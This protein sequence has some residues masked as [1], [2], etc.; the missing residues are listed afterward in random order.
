MSTSSTA[1]RKRG[2]HVTIRN[3]DLFC[4]HCGA[5]QTVPYPIDISVFV[6]MG[7]AF[8]KVHANC[9]K[10]WRQPEP[11]P[12]WDTA[13]RAHF[14][15]QNG[16][17]GQSSEVIFAVMTGEGVPRHRAHPLD[18]DDFRRCYLLLIT[19]PEWRENMAF[20]KPISPAWNNLVDRWDELTAMLEEMMAGE[21]STAM[22]DL[23]QKLIN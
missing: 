16:E 13:R 14:W 18:P 9:E 5:K 1:K 23:M 19:L 15:W 8:T 21:K 6:A 7:N 11:D 17:R 3:S 20:L 10:T 2:D 12:A 22:Y 4:S